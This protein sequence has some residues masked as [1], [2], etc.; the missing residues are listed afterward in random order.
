VHWTLTLDHRA[1]GWLTPGFHH[2]WQLTLLHASARYGL[3]CPCYVLMPDHIHLIWLGLRDDADQRTA[4]GFLRKHLRPALAPHDWQKQ[5]HDHVLRD[6]ERVSNHRPL[7]PRKP[8]PCRPLCHRRGLR[9]HRLLRAGLS[10]AFCPRGG[11]L[12]AFLAA[13]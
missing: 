12:A 7:H 3:A 10:R 11:L 6:V 9:L 2:T 8:R 13:L 1:T 4:I 5:A